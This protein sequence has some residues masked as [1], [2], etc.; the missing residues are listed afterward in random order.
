V[1]FRNNSQS[2][3]YDPF[4]GQFEFNFPHFLHPFST[5]NTMFKSI[6][7]LQPRPSQLTGGFFVPVT[8]RIVQSPLRSLRLN[9]MSE[10][11]LNQDILSHLHNVEKIYCKSYGIPTHEYDT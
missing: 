4:N 10:C 11:P 2:W 8:R 3:L 1:T 5:T 7:N 6:R 9:L